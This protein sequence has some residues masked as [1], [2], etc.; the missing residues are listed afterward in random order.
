M[1]AG[2]PVPVHVGEVQADRL[3][4]A[5]AAERLVGRA[6]IVAAGRELHGDQHVVDR[7]R[8]EADP[9]ADA[10]AIAVRRILDLAV[11]DSLWT[12]LLVP[13]AQVALQLDLAGP[14]RA[15]DLGDLVGRHRGFLAQ[16]LGLGLQVIHFR[17]APLDHGLQ[18]G[19]LRL[20]GV[21]GGLEPVESLRQRLELRLHGLPVGLRLC[22]GIRGCQDQRSGYGRRQ[23]SISHVGALGSI[24]GKHG[25]RR[26][27]LRVS[28]PGSRGRFIGWKC[29][30]F[31]AVNVSAM[32]RAT[33]RRRRNRAGFPRQ[34]PFGREMT[35]ERASCPLAALDLQPP[36]M[37][38]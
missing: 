22:T 12:D 16:V 14:V 36:A 11:D 28:E 9:P 26:T 5:G 18:V 2:K 25:R 3:R 31:V 32:L 33:G 24:F 19:V 29:Y 23:E 27:A 13:V 21:V 38:L 35:G 15:L 37:T 20:Q 17:V 7:L 30:R 4:R 10:V 1:R 6:G 8:L 34:Q